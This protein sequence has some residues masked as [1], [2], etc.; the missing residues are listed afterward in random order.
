MGILCVKQQIE[1]VKVSNLSPSRTTKLGFQGPADI[2]ENPDKTISH[3]ERIITQ[4][5]DAYYNTFKSENNIFIKSWPSKYKLKGWF[6]R[7]MKNGHHTSHIHQTGWLSG[8]IYLKTI[9]L[10]NNLSVVLI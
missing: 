3:L 8:V 7:L 2:F 1:A 9:N 6:N 5:I 4:A 10:S